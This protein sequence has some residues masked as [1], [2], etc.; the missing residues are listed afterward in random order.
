[1][2]SSECVRKF[3]QMLAGH[4]KYRVHLLTFGRASV[5]PL[6]GGKKTNCCVFSCSPCSLFKFHLHMSRL[7]IDM[8]GV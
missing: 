1:M 6:L 2:K 7:F 5:L 8:G 4:V 3:L